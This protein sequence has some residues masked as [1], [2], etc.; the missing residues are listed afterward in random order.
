MGELRLTHILPPPDLT[1]QRLLFLASIASRG[2]S[3]DPLD[4][5]ILR[6]TDGVRGLPV[7]LLATFPFTEG[8]RRESAIV[9]DG[10]GTLIAASKG[11]TE[12]RNNFV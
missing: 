1:A 2:D 6:E 5:A 8:R 7:E 3:G 10:D 12:T 4:T 9:R 11:A